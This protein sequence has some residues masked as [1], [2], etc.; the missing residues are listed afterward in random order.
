MHA[1]EKE[2]SIITDFIFTEKIATE[3]RLPAEIAPQIQQLCIQIRKDDVKYN[4]HP[5]NNNVGRPAWKDFG[6]PKCYLYYLTSE[7]GDCLQKYF[8]SYIIHNHNKE[9]ERVE[10]IYVLES[11][12]DYK[13]FKTIPIQ[14]RRYLTKIPKTSYEG[15]GYSHTDINEYKVLRVEYG[16]EN[17]FEPKAKFIIHEEKVE[18]AQPIIYQRQNIQ[19]RD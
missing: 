5:Y 3:Y 17:D 13:V 1:M 9:K 4:R 19:Y 6:I 18:N 7:Q 12:E 8:E 2:T 14:I 10:M 11:K 15:F 16:E